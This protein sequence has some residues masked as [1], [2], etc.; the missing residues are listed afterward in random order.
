[1]LNLPFN[2]KFGSTS[3]ST[4]LRSINW[5]VRPTS[6]TRNHFIPRTI[7]YKNTNKATYYII[8]TYYNRSPIPV[9]HPTVESH[10]FFFSSSYTAT[11]LLRSVRFI[12]ST[13]AYLLL[14]Y[15]TLVAVAAENLHARLCTY[16]RYVR[17]CILLIHSPGARETFSDV[18]IS[19]KT[20]RVVIITMCT[21]IICWY[22]YFECIIVNETQAYRFDVVA[23]VGVT[24][25]RENV[26]IQHTVSCVTDDT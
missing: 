8:S 23:A 13:Q 10:P 9:F 12:F 4:T 15:G 7:S 26:Q 18:W 22:K 24:W 1:M 16:S 20:L 11:F 14:I 6:F 21:C 19:S 3:K 5:S 2:K 17:R 25:K